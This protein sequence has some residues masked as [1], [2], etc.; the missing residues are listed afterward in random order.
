MI[1]GNKNRELS[2]LSINREFRINLSN[3]KDRII[4]N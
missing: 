1:F 3:F 4:N 2:I